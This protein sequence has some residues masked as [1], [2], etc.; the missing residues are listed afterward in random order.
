MNGAV[1]LSLV[2]TGISDD[3]TLV[4]ILVYLVFQQRFSGIDFL[5][6]YLFFNFIIKVLLLRII[7]VLVIG[8]TVVVFYD[9]AANYL[10]LVSDIVMFDFV[11]RD[12]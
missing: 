7:L 1:N 12:I 9:V 3:N 10:F 8:V 5:I 6:S 11:N 4:D 2:G